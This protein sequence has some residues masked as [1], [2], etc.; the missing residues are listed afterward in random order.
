M[1]SSNCALVIT[2]REDNFGSS[3]TPL[4]HILVMTKVEYFSKK[5]II[6]VHHLR[7]LSLPLVTISRIQDVAIADSI[8]FTKIHTYLPDFL[9]LYSCV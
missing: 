5:K 1:Q 2:Q 4:F 9:A 7:S 8:H 3:T 6:A